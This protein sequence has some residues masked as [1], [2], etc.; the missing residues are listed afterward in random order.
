MRRKREFCITNENSEN[1]ENNYYFLINNN[2]FEVL[3]NDINLENLIFMYNK[4]NNSAI[5][6]TNNKN[7]ILYVNDKWI[8]ICK[9]KKNE[10]IGKNINILQG[11][12]TNLIICKKFTQELYLNDVSSMNII[13]YD[14][15]NNKINI[16]VQAYKI[17]YKNNNY[18]NNNS[19]IFI[20]II[21]KLIV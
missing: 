12:E 3:F 4:N 13:N 11:K 21:K 18:K 20:S 8:E 1:S 7:E 17:K 15:N 14:K 6:L 5:T 9:Y 16:N 19:P 10:I 2:I